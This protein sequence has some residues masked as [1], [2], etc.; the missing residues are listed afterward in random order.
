MQDSHEPAD[1]AAPQN[2]PQLSRAARI[3]EHIALRARRIAP[4][5]SLSLGI[6]SALLMERGPKAGW[7]IALAAVGVWLLLLVQRQLA[8]ATE[9]KKPWLAGV[10]RVAR[11]SSL[12]A[13]QSLL[14]MK[15]FFALP[16]FVQAAD[17]SEPAHDVF[18]FGL[19]SFCGAALWDPW[20]ERWL[21]RRHVATLLPAAA[22]FV[23]LAA[24]LPGLGLSTRVSL[25][26]AA[27][28]GGAGA[29]LLLILHEPRG[30][31]LRRVPYAALIAVAM[32]AA[33]ALGA[34]RMVPAAPLRLV[35]IEFGNQLRDHWIVQ[36]L[37]SY[38]NAPARLYC[39]T[40]I[41]SPLGVH[42]QLLHVWRKDGQVRARIE[43]DVQ[44]GR[45]SGFRTASRIP[46]APSEA[47][48]F[49][50]S[51][52]SAGGQVLGGKSIVLRAR[53]PYTRYTSSANP[54]PRA[55]ELR[56]L[57]RDTNRSGSCMS[58]RHL[59]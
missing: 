42:D 45:D 55:Q 44:G 53:E 20:T 36:P 51:V 18:I 5:F 54:G 13:T 37:K 15:L 52:E 31:R 23:S 10:V 59:V 28:V 9:P 16:F 6:V 32:P 35:T 39:A 3:W 40:A 30:E 58:L 47:G 22:S 43:L 33:L 19:V 12:M 1:T 8:R 29:A 26:I 48:R 14:Q 2:P 56:D 24:V 41:A 50:C 57:A 11:R 21:A 17:F 4:W 38:G 27:G 7:R 25:W 49:R 34:N 46:V